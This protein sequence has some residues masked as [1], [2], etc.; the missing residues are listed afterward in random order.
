[1]RVART[2]GFDGS[3]KSR[4]RCPGGSW[5]LPCAD[6][7]AKPQPLFSDLRV[8]REGRGGV[9]DWVEV[10]DLVV[11]VSPGVVDASA[12]LDEEG[13]A[14]G[15]VGEPGEALADVECVGGGS[16][17]VGQEW[18]GEVEGFAVAG[19]G[20]GAVA[21]DGEHGDVEVEEVLASVTQEL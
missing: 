2:V 9:D 16:G 19:V 15:D 20:E 1:V 3:G 4:F 6:P 18:D 17:P 8:G 5:L 10:W 7:D 14:G 11:G 13:C 12:A 21:A